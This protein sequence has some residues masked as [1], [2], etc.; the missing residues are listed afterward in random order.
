MAS[1]AVS[2]VAKAVIMMTTVSGEISLIV[3]ST[4]MPPG[5]WARTASVPWFDPG[6]LPETLAACEEVLRR[7]PLAVLA[8]RPDS[9]A[10]RALEDFVSAC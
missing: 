1:M 2:V 5:S 4:S 8:F 9:G 10:V 3:L 7:V 6:C